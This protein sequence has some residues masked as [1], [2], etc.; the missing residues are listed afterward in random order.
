MDGFVLRRLRENAG[1]QAAAGEYAGKP[2]IDHDVRHS[3]A[4]I[5]FPSAIQTVVVGQKN[6]NQDG[7]QRTRTWRLRWETFSLKSSGGAAALGDAIVAALEPEADFGEARFG[8]GF[9]VFERSG[10]TEDV[11]ELTIFRRI[12]DMEITATY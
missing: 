5:A 8:R 10:G 4:K 11:G 12:Y 2:A 9:L 3:N 6:Y 7:S 1:V